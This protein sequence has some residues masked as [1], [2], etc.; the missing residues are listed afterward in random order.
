MK[1]LIFLFLSF[2]VLSACS[3]NDDSASDSAVDNSKTKATIILK[4][5]SGAAVS[6]IVVY[7]YDETTWEIIGDNPLFAD[8]QAASD[9]QGIS[10][11][12]NIFSDSAFRPSNNFQN[13]FRF[14]A[15]YTLNGNAKTK[16]IAITFTKGE[17]KSGTIILN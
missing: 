5:A 2:A 17:T 12:E 14:S 9:S 4:N 11:F 16:N 15:H 13:T 10:N 1:K 7:A 3:S 8:F 6:N